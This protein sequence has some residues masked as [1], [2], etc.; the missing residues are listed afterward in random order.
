MDTIFKQSFLV[1]LTFMDLNDDED[2]PQNIKEPIFITDINE[3]KAI[4]KAIEH[5]TYIL[6]DRYY[7]RNISIDHASPPKII[8]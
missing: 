2:F 1:I 5:S 6:K 8:D 7:L 3:A 4:T